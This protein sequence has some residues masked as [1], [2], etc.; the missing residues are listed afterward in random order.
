MTKNSV[1]KTFKKKLLGNNENTSRH[2]IFIVFFIIYVVMCVYYLYPLF[3]TLSNSLKSVEEYYDS[4]LALPKTW[5][6][7]YYVKIFTTFR[8]G[9][10]G[11]WTMAVNSFWLAFGSQILN[12]LASAMLAYPLARYNFPGKNF[13]YGVIVFRI[14]IPIIGGSAAGYKLI[15]AL[16]ML[17]NPLPYSLTWFMGFD[18][19]ALIMYG[20]FKGISKEYSEAAYMDG[21]TRLQT[22]LTV[23]LPQAIPCIIALYISNVM[24][25][26]N[27][28]SESMLYLTKFPN[29]AYGL[30]LFQD[31][32]LFVEGGTP[33]FYGAIILSAIVPIV[34]FMVGQ[35]TMLLNMSVGGL[36]G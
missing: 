23:V 34:L 17:N 25:R 31:E 27:Q 24:G 36:K 16:N 28:Y 1:F 35:K 2:V 20:Y 15:R 18:M 32:V 3:W 4:T 14:T 30:Y 26:W 10:A 13:L 33:M 5:D 11:F 22:L 9:E 29:L 19:S 7:G 8:V 12:L 6:F 21:A